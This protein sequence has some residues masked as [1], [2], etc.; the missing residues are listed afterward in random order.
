MGNDRHA[1]AIGHAGAC[2]FRV[3]AIADEADGE[4]R[5]ARRGLPAEQRVRHA[6]CRAFRDVCGRWHKPK[7]SLARHPEAN[8]I[9]A[10]PQV[11]CESVAC[12]QDAEGAAAD[13]DHSQNSGTHSVSPFDPGRDGPEPR[14]RIGASGE[15]LRPLPLQRGA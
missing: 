11:I 14:D 1:L 7:H 10:L 12:K 9:K 2:S 3:D 6:E 4:S 5:A 15:A 13:K 8:E